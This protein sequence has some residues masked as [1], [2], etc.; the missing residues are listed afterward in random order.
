MLMTTQNTNKNIYDISYPCYIAGIPEGE[1]IAHIPG[2]FEYKALEEIYGY[3]V[4]GYKRN[5]RIYLFDCVPM[6]LWFKQK[7]FVTYEKRLKTLRRL[8]NEQ[9]GERTLVTDLPMVLCDTHIDTI[10]YLDNL[11]TMGYKRARIMYSHGH[12]VF[13]ESTKDEYIEIEL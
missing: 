11:L 3:V 7:C 1:R 12:Y 5:D 9:I 10:E 13:G 6:E 4:E 8:I 2:S